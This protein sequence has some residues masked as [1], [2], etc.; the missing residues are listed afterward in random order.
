MSGGFVYDSNLG[1]FREVLEASRRAN[2]AIYF[3]DARGLEM[4]AYMTAEFGAPL[5]ARDIGFTFFEKH[6]A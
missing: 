2:A 3:L 6:L 4:P 5:D 1:G